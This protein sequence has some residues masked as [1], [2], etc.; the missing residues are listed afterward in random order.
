MLELVSCNKTS[1]IN[2]MELSNSVVCKDTTFL[3]INEGIIAVSLYN[4]FVL[5]N[6]KIK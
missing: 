1:V 6:V 4:V 2:R 3:K 5:L